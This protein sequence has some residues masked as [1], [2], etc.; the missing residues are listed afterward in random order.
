MNSTT[1]Q[2]VY[3]TLKENNTELSNNVEILN[4]YVIIK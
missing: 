4:K 2:M 1:N 3:R